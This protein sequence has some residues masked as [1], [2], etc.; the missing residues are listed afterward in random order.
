MTNNKTFLHYIP[1]PSLMCLYMLIP[2]A[3]PFGGAFFANH[4]RRRGIPLLYFVLEQQTPSSSIDWL[5][6]SYFVMEKTATLKKC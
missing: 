6:D 4:T 1:A 2:A 3:R 5:L